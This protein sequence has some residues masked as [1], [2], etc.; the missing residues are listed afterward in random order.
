MEEGDER[1]HPGNTVH[2]YVEA[3]AIDECLN[4][5]RDKTATTVDGLDEK[6]RPA[7]VTGIVQNMELGR[8]PSA[9]HQTRVTVFVAPD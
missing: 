9:K 5:I 2:L 7:Q 6:G 8:G 1:M 4:S 3:E